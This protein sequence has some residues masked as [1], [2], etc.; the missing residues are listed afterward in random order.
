MSDQTTAAPTTTPMSFDEFCD[1]AIART[2]AVAPQ[3]V[4][5][6]SASRWPATDKGPART[7]YSI[8]VWD[9]SKPGCSMGKSCFVITDNDNAAKCLHDLG[10]ELAALKARHD[11]DNPS[12]VAADE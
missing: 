8:Q 9:S 4:G 11:Y 6:P 2:A 3:Y 5:Y 1:Q 10:R 7:S 12:P